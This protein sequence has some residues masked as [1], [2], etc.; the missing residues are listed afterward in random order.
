[1]YSNKTKVALADKFEVHVS[2]RPKR[3]YTKEI[4]DVA[5]LVI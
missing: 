5:A 2:L 1:M 4:S 3:I